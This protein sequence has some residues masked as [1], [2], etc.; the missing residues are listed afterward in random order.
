MFKLIN[1]I[2]LKFRS[3]FKRKRTW[4][5]FVCATVAFM[6]RWEHRGVTSII[7][8]LGLKSRYYES[9]LHFFRSSAYEPA[10]IWH[11]WVGV[12]QEQ[13]TFA[14]ESGYVILVAD[15][16]KV[17]KEGRRM[18]GVQPFH[19]ASENAGKRKYA[20]GHQF[21]VVSA[22][23]ICGTEARSV[24]LS[25]EIQESKTKTG[26]ESLIELMIQQGG[27]V[28]ETL[29]KPV[30]LVLDAYYCAGS[31]FKTADR[32]RDENGKPRLAVI[33]RAKRSTTAFTEPAPKPKG[34]PGAPR[35]YGES[36]KLYELFESAAKEFTE[37]EIFLYG[38][39]QKVRYLCRDLIW[40][41]AGEP[42]GAVRLIRFVLVEIVGAGKRAALMCGDLDLSPE[43]II[44]VY[45]LRFKIETS[46]DDLKNDLGCF[47]YHFWTKALPKKKKWKNVEIPADEKSI[48][49]IK[50]ASQAIEM[51]VCLCCIAAG[52]LTIIGFRYSREIW[53]AFPGWLRTIRSE[54]PSIATTRS[55][56][57]QVFQGGMPDFQH[58]PVFNF[59]ASQRRISHRFADAA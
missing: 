19:Q 49:D 18:P 32:Y 36:V 28:L 16:I 35:K 48:L 22:I 20:E 9:V 10:D 58:L 57:A 26:K 29:E 59:I 56:F 13:L 7:S 21:G 12:A 54:V 51:H 31:T 43:A 50:K 42:K 14:E 11:K 15:P 38:K 47:D 53:R 34:Q 30:L 39:K 45:G 52:L 2:L 5:W 44:R 27:N 40:K 8:S 23:A 55:A 24:P 37:G 6:V 1:D 17:A 33:T 25:A 46:F 4:N 3:C 41:P